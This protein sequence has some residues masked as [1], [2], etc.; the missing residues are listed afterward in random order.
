MIVVV[1]PFS[2]PVS[3]SQGRT[4][5]IVRRRSK[6]D[7]MNFGQ[8]LQQIGLALGKQKLDD[9][10]ISELNEGPLLGIES[11]V[12]AVGNRQ[13]VDFDT[14]EV[15]ASVGPLALKNFKRQGV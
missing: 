13:H 10:S 9:A 11:R 15:P 7:T 14:F 3:G 8:T 6:G 4:N 5:F 1:V 2:R 12:G